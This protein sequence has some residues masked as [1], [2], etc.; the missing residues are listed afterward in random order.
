M[1]F[2]QFQT[3]DFK[4]KAVA[5]DKPLLE[6][7]VQLFCYCPMS[8]AIGELA[9][10]VYSKTTL[11]GYTYI[12]ERYVNFLHKAESWSFPPNDDTWMAILMF[13]PSSVSQQAY[14]RAK[15]AWGLMC[16]LNNI[17]FPAWVMMSF[18]GMAKRMLRIR[19]PKQPQQHQDKTVIMDS[20]LHTAANATTKR[21]HLL[22]IANLLGYYGG[23][24][25]T[26]SVRITKK[27]VFFDVLGVVITPNT[28]KN[29]RKNNSYHQAFIPYISEPG[30]LDVGSLFALAYQEVV[31]EDLFLFTEDN[32]KLITSSTMMS[33]A[34]SFYKQF[35]FTSFTV[36]EYR[37]FAATNLLKRNKA[38]D[39]DTMMGWRSRLAQSFYVLSDKEFRFEESYHL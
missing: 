18:D 26:D 1:S 31:G 30:R 33:H 36:K 27:S 14:V 2:T 19:E 39:V 12:M 8:K 6:K 22:V 34:R 35:K 38:D 3:M 29:D 7:A 15:A 5:I 10:S 21:D 13:R 28:K 17:P 11:L 16:R 32:G 20:F 25:M 4:N 37:K 24:R 23:F 9:L